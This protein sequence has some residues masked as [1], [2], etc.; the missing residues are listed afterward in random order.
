MFSKSFH[1]YIEEYSKAHETGLFC[2]VGTT[3]HEYTFS[4]FLMGVFACSNGKKMINSV[5]NGQ[6]VPEN[7]HYP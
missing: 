7:D 3:I 2:V 4:M 6:F 5:T 1:R